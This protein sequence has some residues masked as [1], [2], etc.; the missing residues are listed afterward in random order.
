MS[1]INYD[2]DP[3]SG[4]RTTIID[5]DGGWL[6]AWGRTRYISVKEASNNIKSCFN[7]WTRQINVVI[8]TMTW[9]LHTYLSLNSLQLYCAVNSD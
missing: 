2:A 9:E 4:F 1:R 6:A 7:T 8:E 3:G 5:F